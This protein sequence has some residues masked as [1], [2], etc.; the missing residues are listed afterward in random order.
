VTIKLSHAGTTAWTALAD[1]T[2]STG[3]GSASL[4]DSFIA[5]LLVH[6]KAAEVSTSALDAFL[7]IKLEIVAVEKWP[8]RETDAGAD[9]RCFDGTQRGLDASIVKTGDTASSECGM[10][11]E[12]VQAALERI[13]GETCECVV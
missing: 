2:T 10:G 3:V 13:R 9:T 11:K 6:C 7:G 4:G 12:K 1:L 5:K 8:G